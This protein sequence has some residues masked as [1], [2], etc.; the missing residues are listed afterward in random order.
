MP[1]EQSLVLRSPR[2]KSRRQLQFKTGGVVSTTVTVWLH[3][4]VA[5][6]SSTPCQVWVITHGQAPLVTVLTTVTVT[7]PGSP[8]E[9]GQALVQV[10]GSK[11]QLGPHSPVLFGAH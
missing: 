7:L 2:A 5:P 10:G 4:E 8:A 6:Q 9:L 1:L 3:V 11:V